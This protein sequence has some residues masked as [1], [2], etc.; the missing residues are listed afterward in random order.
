MSQDYRN[1][2]K[3]DYFGQTIR[4]RDAS[5]TESFSV[6]K[7]VEGE[8]GWSTPYDMDRPYELYKEIA[9]LNARNP[10]INVEIANDVPNIK[11]SKGVCFFC[12]D[13]IISQQGKKLSSIG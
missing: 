10:G 12:S 3:K 5:F 6:Y 4:A 11:I 7:L 8:L 9:K 13:S 1:Y 2:F